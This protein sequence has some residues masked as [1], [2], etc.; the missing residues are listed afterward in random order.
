MII[1]SPVTP[2]YSYSQLQA[3]VADYL[4]RN[5]L[6][7]V[8]P[9][10]ISRAEDYLFRELNIKSLAFS[11]SGTTT[12]EYAELPSDFQ[13]VS[14]VTVTQ[15]SVEYALDYKSE[16]AVTERSTPYAY[17]LEN[18]Q[19]RI[20]GAGTG[21]AYVLYYI[22]KITALSD[23]NTSNWLLENAKDLYFYTT[24]LEAAR[25]IRNEAEM[26]ALPGLVAGSLDSV[27][28]LSERK[29]QPANASLQIKPRR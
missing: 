17:A 18:N 3:D 22:P 25:Y 4:H 19:I 2:L 8:M 11:I 5:D 12:G 7:G 27:R 28:R 16:N 21:Q 13:T 15:G 14:K 6:A 10:F 20:F 26:A 24:A 23:S 1:V 9:T 29:G